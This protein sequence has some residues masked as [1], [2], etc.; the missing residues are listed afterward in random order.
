VAKKVVVLGLDGVPYTLLKR[1][2]EEG[3]MPHTRDLLASGTLA[4]MDTALPEISSTAW[5]SFMTGANPGRHGVYGFMDL[6]PKTYKLQFTNFNSVKTSTVWDYLSRAGQR[7]M[8]LN[9]PTTYPA[10]DLVGVLISGFV[11]IDLKRAT[12]PTSLVPYLEQVGYKLDVDTTTFK[13]GTDA[14]VAELWDALAKRETVLW[15]LLTEE[16]WSLY[17]GVVTETDRLHHYMWAAI[18]DPAHKYHG[19]FKDYYRKVDAF[20]GR[21]FEKVGKDALFMIMSDHGFCEIEQEV[22]LNRWLEEEGYLAF[23]E[24]PPQSHQSIL[25]STRA[26]NMDPARIYVHRKGAYAKGSVEAKD[27][28]GIIDEI[29]EKLRTLTIGGK[30]VIDK[31]WRKDELYS[32]L[33]LPQGP[34]LVLLPHRGFDLKGTI[35]QKSIYGRSVLTGMHT[36]DDAVFFVNRPIAKSGKAHIMDIAPTILA[37]LGIAMPQGLDGVPLVAS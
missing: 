1:F 6:D 26:F 20:I 15:K 14:F 13:N 16:E 28:P 7:S 30:P 25:E 23:S 21:V 11:A 22:Y 35:I 29:A 33:Y 36:Q 17:I 32:G 8:V 10:R 31:I 9:I 4:Q 3:V 2:A 24:N 37:H 5:T 27:A 18:E 34:D 19:F 12:F